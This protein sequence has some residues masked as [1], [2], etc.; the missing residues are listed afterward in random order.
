MAIPLG[1]ST[2]A[3]AQ[4]WTVADNFDEEELGIVLWNSHRIGTAITHERS[5]GR[6]HLS[7]NAPVYDFDQGGISSKFRV[8][9]DFELQVDYFLDQWPTT[10]GTMVGTGVVSQTSGAAVLLNRQSVPYS[11]TVERHV[12]GRFLSTHAGDLATVT[13]GTFRLVRSGNQFTGFVAPVGTTDWVPVSTSITSTSQN[14][15]VFLFAATYLDWFSGTEVRTSLDNFRINFTPTKRGDADFDG[16]VFF[17]DLLLLAQHYGQTGNATWPD[18][19]FTRDGNVNFDDLLVLAQNYYSGSTL[20][21]ELFASPQFNSDWQLA[22]SL[23]PEP[24]SLGF[25]TLVGV[26]MRRWRGTTVI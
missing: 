11:G 7:V 22:R 5:D 25:F 21:D 15:S 8:N 26:A 12:V 3:S 16:G 13:E 1:L 6:L 18:G 23:V 2:Y 10:N 19:D 24:L 17:S 14:M 20:Q 9:G 4:V